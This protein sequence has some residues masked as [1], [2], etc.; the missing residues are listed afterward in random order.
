MSLFF[1]KPTIFQQLI[2]GS[3]EITYGGQEL[4]NLYEAY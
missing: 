4:Q 2:Y 3:P 1:T